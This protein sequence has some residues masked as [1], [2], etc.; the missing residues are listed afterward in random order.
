M[1]YAY[2]SLVRSSHREVIDKYLEH[3]PTNQEV[4]WVSDFQAVL[5]KAKQGDTFLITLNSIYL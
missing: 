3:N 1:I 2:T 4:V 5:N